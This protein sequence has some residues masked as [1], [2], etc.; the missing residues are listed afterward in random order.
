[1]AKTAAEIQI[2]D[3]LVKLSTIIESSCISN[4]QEAQNLM[5][6]L[7][8]F[9]RLQNQLVRLAQ[10]AVDQLHL[11]IKYLLFDLD[12]TRRERDELRQYL[13]NEGEDL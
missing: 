9:C 13:Q 6:Q 12:A 3:H 10:D 7:R 1:M 4:K 8:S 11:D 5:I 2:N